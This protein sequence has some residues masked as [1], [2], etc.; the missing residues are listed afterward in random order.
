MFPFLL[1]LLAGLGTVAALLIPLSGRLA[2]H[3]WPGPTVKGPAD[4][5]TQAFQAL[6]CLAGL[7]IVVVTCSVVGL[8]IAT[9]AGW[10]LGLWIS[11][12]PVAI[13]VLAVAGLAFLRGK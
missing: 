12:L 2:R 10:T 7:G 3:V 11:G 1:I 9:W 8:V 13:A 6:V 4:V 5:Y